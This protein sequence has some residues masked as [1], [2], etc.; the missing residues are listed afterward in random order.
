LVFLRKRKMPIKLKI[1]NKNI[2]KLKR[3]SLENLLEDFYI[4]MKLG[5]LASVK[6]R[7]RSDQIEDVKDFFEFDE[8]WEQTDENDIPYRYHILRGQIKEKCQNDFFKK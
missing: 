3:F 6:K 5:G 4:D 2:S 1:P 8:F 7:I